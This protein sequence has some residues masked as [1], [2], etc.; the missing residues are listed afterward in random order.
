MSEKEKIKKASEKLI[1]LSLSIN[2]DYN[3][4]E[5]EEISNDE[6]SLI[7]YF[8]DKINFDK[9]DPDLYSVKEKLLSLSNR[10]LEIDN[11]G[12]DD[13]KVHHQIRDFVDMLIIIALPM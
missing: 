4:K 6:I 12:Y 7:N 11:N 5:K 2:K 13:E 3:E 10:I 9:I 1:G 8:I